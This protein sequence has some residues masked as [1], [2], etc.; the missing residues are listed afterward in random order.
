MGNLPN[1]N[2]DVSFNNFNDVPYIPYKIIQAMYES[3]SI[4]AENFWKCLKYT[5]TEALEQPNLTKKQKIALIWKGNDTLENNYQ[6]FLKPLIG[7]QLT[8]AAYRDW[9]TDRK[10]TRL[11]SSHEIPSRMPS[12]A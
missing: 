7:S 5:T 6:V 3:T 1:G 4:E 8:D 10:S 2:S 11:N 9:E 12:S